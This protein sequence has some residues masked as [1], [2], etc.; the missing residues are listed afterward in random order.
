M[1]RKIILTTMS[2]L[3]FVTR[4]FYMVDGKYCDGISQLEAGTKYYLSTVKG[5]DEIIAIGSNDVINEGDRDKNLL[6]KSK[7]EGRNIIEEYVTFDLKGSNK[8]PSAYEVYCYGIYRFINGL[9]DSSPI[10]FDS[11]KIS[12]TRKNEIDRI[13][14]GI[15]DSNL[16]ERIKSINISLKEDI[17]KEYVSKDKKAEYYEKYK[18]I[19]DVNEDKSLDNSEKQGIFQKMLSALQEKILNISENTEVTLPRKELEDY[20]KTIGKLIIE[21]NDIKTNRLRTE[22]QYVKEKVYSDISDDL[23]LRCNEENKDVVISFV[24]VKR[25]DY[26]T[27]DNLSELVNAIKSYDADTE[28]YLDMQGGSRTDGYVRSAVL[29]LL[30]NEKTKNVH[31]KQIIA[32]DFNSRNFINPIVDETY[33]YRIT[34]LVSGMNAFIN[35]GKAEQLY[36]TWKE[37][38]KN[39]KEDTIS[40]IIKNMQRVDHALSL[41]DVNELVEAVK[42]LYKNSKKKI[43]VTDSNKEFMKVFKDNILEDYKGI[44]INDEVDI[45]EL[46][47]WAVRKG[48]VQQAITLIESKMPEQ[49]VKDGYFSYCEKNEDKVAVSNAIAE[50]GDFKG[51]KADD[52]DHM[53]FQIIANPDNVDRQGKIGA[54]LHTYRDD[55]TVPTL[56]NNI[57]KQRN[58]TAHVGEKSLTYENTMRMIEE[59]IKTYEVQKKLIYQN[60]DGLN[61]IHLTK[62]EVDDFYRKTHVY[63]CAVLN[64]DNPDKLDDIEEKKKAKNRMV[65][66]RNEMLKVMRNQ[67]P[68]ENIEAKDIEL[69][70][71]NRVAGQI[72]SALNRKGLVY[73]TIP[74]NLFNEV[75][76][77]INTKITAKGYRIYVIDNKKQCIKVL[78]D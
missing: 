27:V 73:M 19:K 52:L 36:S 7:Y 43:R 70:F 74:K 41:C 18:T 50:L 49:M 65:S 53:L 13:I 12:D 67:L 61:E 6:L 64:I 51:Y 63:F 48:F 56:Y 40:K 39:R 10:D 57:R 17:E 54:F 20:Q 44:V 72:E 24:G 14:E 35:Y 15:N 38:N 42:E 34:D 59:F 68:N 3:N 37:L 45:F 71:K 11:G 23:K 16:A 76:D 62:E 28:I 1:T 33:R 47:K 2:T 78:H 22:Q 60:S 26:E 58:N 66:Y 77:V 5:I 8:R 21:I 9:S 25:K 69:I 29:S 75:E 55:S 46:V 30:N 31:L 4:N 32:T